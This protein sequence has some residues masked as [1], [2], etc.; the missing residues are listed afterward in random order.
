[1]E[2]IIS[3]HH[4][5]VDPNKVVL[6]S[7][8][9]RQLV[10][11]VASVLDRERRRLEEQPLVRIHVLGFYGGDV[12]EKRVELV[13]A[14]EKSAPLTVGLAGHRPPGLEMRSNIPTVFGNLDDAIA[15]DLQVVPD[16]LERFR[17]RI[18]ARETDNGEQIARAGAGPIPG[19]YHTV[20]GAGLITR[21]YD[22]VVGADISGGR[23]DALVASIMVHRT[24]HN[25]QHFRDLCGV[26]RH[27][28][29][30]CKLLCEPILDRRKPF[31][32]LQR[33]E[34]KVAAYCRLF[35]LGEPHASFFPKGP[36]E[37]KRLSAA[38]A[39]LHKR[40]TCVSE[41]VLERVA[42]AVVALTKVALSCG[43]RREQHET[44]ERLVARF[45]VE[46]V[47]AGYLRCDHTLERLCRFA[48]NEAVFNDART[49]QH[50]I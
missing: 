25:A 36:I 29:H 39:V 44:I 34:A 45:L 32:G 18:T 10:R 46:V 2:L 47:G 42:E 37:R 13:D 27:H 20:A 8:G 3:P 49:V 12:E 4:S 19:R 21:R 5:G 41:V 26:A 9:C 30:L 50:A 28:D 6:Q 43:H 15:A 38:L 16:L 24:R 7:L 33:H 23:R 11:S 22:T 17:L 31:S 35:L 14:A 1:M 40:P 48:N